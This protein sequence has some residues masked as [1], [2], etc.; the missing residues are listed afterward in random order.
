MTRD[1]ALRLEQSKGDHI[2]S[3]LLGMKEQSGNPFGVDILRRGKT[4]VFVARNL[5]E[6]GLF[7]LVIGFGSQDKGYL[8]EIMQLYRDHGVEQYHVEINPYHVSPDFLTSIAE[9]GLSL[10]RFETYLYGPAPLEPAF[11]SD[12]VTIREVAPSELELFAD[13]HVE[14]YQEA[15][16][17]VP[18]KTLKLYRECTK[19]V[20][21]RPGWCLY[22]AWMNALPA[23]MGMLY[24]QDGVALL[25][26]GATLPHLRKHG[27]QTALLR[28]RILTAARAQC[29]LVVAQTNVGSS[30]QQN[31]EK[32]GMRTAYTAT[33][34]ARL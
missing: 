19:V 11:P 26:G 34:V 28:H 20:Y 7:N 25:A 9:Y 8:G 24:M 21:Q 17:R 2:E 16:A 6:I 1:L 12:P 30:S 4:R 5:Q 29:T 32:L 14:G 27:C 23:G 18:E 33:M 15:L 13:I 31:M 3:W 10:S 22:L